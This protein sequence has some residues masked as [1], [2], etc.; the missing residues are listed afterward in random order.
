MIVTQNVYD[1]FA[2]AIGNTPLIKLRRASERTGCNIYGKAEFMEP[3]GSVKDRA[4][5]FLIRDA[6]QK[7]LLRPGSIVVEGTAGN[8]G[9]GLT[10][11]GNSRGYRTIIVIPET[12]SEEKKEFL[13]A[14]GAELVEVPAAP[15]RNP[16]NYVRLSERLA[17]ELGAFWANQFDNPANRRAHEETT[18]PEIWAQLDGQ[19]DAF[20]CAV[21]TG[22]TLTGVGSFLRMKNPKVRIAL[23]DPQGAALVRYYKDGELKAVGESIT[24]GIGQSRITGNLEG[25]TPDMCFEISD[26]EALRE[27]FDLLQYEGLNVG[28]SSG[29]NIAGAVRVAENLGPGH[30]LVTILCDSGS[31]Y[32]KKMFSRSYLQQKNLPVPPWTLEPVKP[33]VASALR[34]VFV[35]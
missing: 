25:F 6:E 13:R 20:N 3:G 29:I 18:G 14:C 16:N 1:S 10:L 22:G 7:G 4:A 12:Q 30:N 33:D 11:V 9:I 5:L 2:N 21:G 23:S 31:R 35:S 19:V 32:Q 17:K 27:A 8:T 15:Y 26:A 28:L 34:K 24:E